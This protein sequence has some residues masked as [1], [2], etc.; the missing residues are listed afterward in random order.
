MTH[1]NFFGARHLLDLAEN[2]RLSERIA[3]KLVYTGYLVRHAAPAHRVS[4]NFAKLHRILPLVTLCPG[5]GA[6]DFALIDVYL[7]FLEKKA[8][9]LAVQ[10]F[11]FASPAI[12]PYEKHALARRAR[13]LPNVEFHRFGKNT[14]QYVKFADLV[15]GDGDYNLTSELLAIRS[16]MIRNVAV[17]FQPDVFLVDHMPR[18]PLL[19][20]TVTITT[21]KNSFWS[22]AAAAPMPPF[23][24]SIY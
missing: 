8:A 13:K 22:P 5:D 21:A 20:P 2:Y 23:Y 14:L 4:K 10:S 12:R 1:C 17:S 15:I 7:R 16:D 6:G 18:R 19:Q 24:G 3:R 11:I 9:G